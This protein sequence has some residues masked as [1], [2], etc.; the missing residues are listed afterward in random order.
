MLVVGVA[1]LLALLPSAAFAVWNPLLTGVPLGNVPSE[2]TMTGTGAGHGV[3]GAIGPVGSVSDPSVPYPATIPAGFTPQDES[4]AGVILA[5]P[6]GGGTPLQ[7]YCINIRTSTFGGVGYNLGS[8][9]E[10]NVTNVGFVARLLNESFPKVPDSPPNGTGI[11]NDNDRA[12]AVQA[13]IWY[14]SDNYV[15]TTTDPLRPAVENLVNTVRAEGPLVQPPPPSLTIAPA[16]ATGPAGPPGTI[17][18]FTV[19]TDDPN[20][21]TVTSNVPMFSDAAGT[22]PVANGTVVPTGTTIWLQSTAGST[23]TLS[24]T[25]TATVP[26]GNVYLY[27][28]NISGVDAA[29]KLILASDATLTT[30][31][32][33]TAQF[34]DTGSLVVRKTIAGSAAGQQG[35]VHISV[36]CNNGALPDF[37]IPAGTT[38]TVEHQYATIPT[39]ATCVITE[40]A[41]GSSPNVTVVTVNGSQTVDL[42]SDTTLE[43]PVDA[44]EITNTYDPTTTTVPSSVAGEQ[45]EPTG[46]AGSS[47]LP[48]TGPGS[49][50]AVVV[51]LGSIGVGVGLLAETRRRRWR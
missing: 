9:E 31:V 3:T 36:V 13:A 48:F 12:A 23:G 45:T 19:T 28:G 21:A 7:L 22:T 14:F 17:G 30:T 11:A 33:A 34:V 20:G 26:T 29:Q 18:P 16:T 24:A 32:S 8:F 39:P 44:G 35:E 10:S 50:A 37:V 38:G 47:S 43:N 49:T 27:S 41:D 2:I 6:A 51:A 1:L 4:F 40:T 25:A 15:L 46:G 42:P 5:T